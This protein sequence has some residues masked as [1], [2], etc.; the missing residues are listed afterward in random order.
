MLE[1]YNVP[2][3]QSYFVEVQYETLGPFLQR[4]DYFAL[5][6]LLQTR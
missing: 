6:T 2:A 4:V 1:L 3:R 5:K